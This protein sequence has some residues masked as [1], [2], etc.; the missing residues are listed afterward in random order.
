LKNKQFHI[1]N[2]PHTR[3]EYEKKMAELNTG[4]IEVIVLA[5]ERVQNLIGKEI[6]KYYHGFNCENVVGDYLYNCRNIFEG[7]DLKNCEDCRYC[8]TLETFTDSQDC[9]FC[10]AASELCFQCVAVDGYQLMCS[11]NCMNACAN[12]SYCNECY[13]CK[14]CFGCA[15]LKAKQYCILNKQYTKEEYESLIPQLIA[16]MKADKEW[17][18]FFPYDL[19]SFAYNETIANEYFPLSKK[20]VL[21]RNWKWKETDEHLQN[22]LGPVLEVPENTVDATDDICSQILRC[23]VT[24][25]LYKIIPQ[26][27]A[28]CKQMNLP[29]PRKCFDQRQRERLATRNPRKLWSRACAK[30]SKDIQ[31]TYSPERPETVVCEECYLKEVY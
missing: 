18:Q 17:G 30:C 16:Q 5:K 23:E 24:G 2:E 10:P 21:S 26:E 29:L 19:S 22:Y 12:L 8:A 6:V 9:N 27:L 15:G 13:G 14:D 3:E 25:K 20:E 7:Y 31:T 1:F 4:R 28:F 11:H